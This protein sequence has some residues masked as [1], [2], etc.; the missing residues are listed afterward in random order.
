MTNGRAESTTRGAETRK[1]ILQAA[2]RCL[3]D[4]GIDGV[5]IARVARLAG[6]STALVHYHFAT[7]EA[8]LAEALEASF[9]VAGEGRANT[10]YGTGPALGRLRRKVEESLP[11]AGRRATEW[12]LWVE[13]WL[14]AVREPALRATAAEVYAQLHRSMRDLIAE[15]AEHGEFAAPDPDGT[16]DRALALIDGFGV[17]A[18]LD[19]PAMPVDR[20]A[21]Q[22]WAVLAAELGVPAEL[23]EPAEP[24]A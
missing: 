11:F 2:V 22:V 16:A 3:A 5:R 10:K 1:R 15:G 23:R 9:Q 14:R 8:L 17:R 24:P 13:L 12:G 19:D 4:A 21:A 18:L 20:A 6:V 7:R